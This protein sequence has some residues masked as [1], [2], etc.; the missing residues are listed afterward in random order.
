MARTALI[1]GGIVVNIIEAGPGYAPPPGVTAVASATANPG[2][3]YSGGV[4]TSGEPAT[5]PA[6][7][8]QAADLDLATAMT[9]D[10][11]VNVAASGAPKIVIVDVSAEG[12]ANMLGLMQK[13]LGGATS[14]SWRQSGGML[15]LSPTEL[16]AASAALEAY[17]EAAYAAWQA[18]HDGIWSSP[19]TIATDAQI[20]ALSWPIRG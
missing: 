17:T 10:I 3:H 4:F 12:K 2:D 8:Q 13:V 20:R 11:S 5:P 18:A 7:L 15:T 9:G 14:I 19:P 1:S 6:A 16:Q